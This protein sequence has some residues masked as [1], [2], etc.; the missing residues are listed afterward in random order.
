[1]S[2]IR[3]GEVVIGR[4]APVF[5]PE[6]LK[7]KS[8]RGEKDGGRVTFDL[9]AL[10]KASGTQATVIQAA[11]YCPIDNLRDITHFGHIQFALN[12][13][14]TEA[15]LVWNLVEPTGLLRVELFIDLV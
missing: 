15:E 9:P 13:A 14:G 3:I 11:W 5:S 1:M 4:A 8:Y 7:P 2:V 12:P 10:L 6:S